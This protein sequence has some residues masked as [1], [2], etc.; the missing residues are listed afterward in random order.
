MLQLLYLS[1]RHTFE[2]WRT[3]RYRRLTGEK[4]IP[5]ILRVSSFHLRDLRP[6]FPTD[7]T[8]CH[9]FFFFFINFRFY[10]HRQGTIR[11]IKAWRTR[12]TARALCPHCVVDANATRSFRFGVQRPRTMRFRDDSSVEQL[13]SKSTSGFICC[14]RA[15]S[16]GEG[17]RRVL[18]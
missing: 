15:F 14:P 10:Q 18:L 2:G 1:R 3:A 7:L 5:L 4:L 8:G 16:G 13:D 12:Q 17:R 6:P 11:L 9:A